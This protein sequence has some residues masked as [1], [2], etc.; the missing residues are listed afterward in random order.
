MMRVLH[1]ASIV[2]G[3]L[4]TAACGPT[5]TRVVSGSYRHAMPRELAEAEQL[6]CATLEVD[7]ENLSATLRPIGYESIALD[8]EPIDESEWEQ[9]CHAKIGSRILEAF[10]VVLPSPLVIGDLVL[11]SVRLFAGCSLHSV[12]LEGT[13]ED[14][15]S[16]ETREVEVMFQDPATTTEHC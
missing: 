7:I 15:D 4:L 8:L 2:A 6:G 13:I 9:G 16:N 10:S 11:E 3:L 12:G 5:V 14:P 1:V